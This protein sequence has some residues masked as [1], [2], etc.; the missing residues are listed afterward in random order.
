MAAYLFNWALNY[1]HSHKSKKVICE[2]YEIAATTCIFMAMKICEIYPPELS[3]LLD[4]LSMSEHLK[5][6]IIGLESEILA[7]LKFN[8]TY[9]S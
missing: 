1:L 3:D 5:K 8:I 4:M 6:P 7:S 9:D 2:I